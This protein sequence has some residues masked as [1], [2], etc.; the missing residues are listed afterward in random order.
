MCGACP[1]KL[2]A[3]VLR[4]RFGTREQSLRISI[5]QSSLTGRES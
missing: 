1:V 5:P 4:L 3:R 2:A